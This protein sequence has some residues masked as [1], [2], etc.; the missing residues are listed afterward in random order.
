M[1]TVTFLLRPTILAYY[2]VDM[3]L[4]MTPGDV[5]LMAGPSSGTRPLTTRFTVTGE[6]MLLDA[7]TVH[8]TPSTI[9]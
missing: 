1:A 9:D 7:R 4:V 2:D 8:F 5:H 6:P 3:H